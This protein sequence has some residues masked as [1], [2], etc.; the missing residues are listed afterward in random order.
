[1]SQLELEKALLDL[2][3]ETRAEIAHRLISSLSEPSEEESDALLA[4]VALKRLEEL[5]SGS[6]KGI[7]GEEALSRARQALQ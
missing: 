3:R 5:K 2:P 1:M 4:K 7:S 6:V